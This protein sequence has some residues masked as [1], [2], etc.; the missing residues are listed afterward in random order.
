MDLGKKLR[1]ALARIAKLPVVDENAVKG[2]IK[3]LQR[4]LISSDVNVKLVFELSKR[5]EKRALHSEK[6]EALTLREHVLKVVYEELVGLMG[7]GYEPKIDK[8][9]ILMVG[10]FGS[11]KTTSTAKLAYFYK[12][13]GL[14]VLVVGADVERPAA[15]EQLEQ[16][17]EKVGVRFFSIKGEK[18][19]AKVVK[20]ALKGIKEDV[21]I[22][23]SAGRSAFDSELSK[24]LKGIYAELKPDETYLVLNADIGQVAGRQAE[25]FSSISPLTGVIVTKMDGSGKGGGALSA[26]AASNAKIAFVGIGEKIND[27]EVYDAKRFV[28]RLLGMPDIK[29]LVE[30]IESIQKEEQLEEMEG[31]ELTIENFYKQLNAAKKMGPLGNVLG[32]MGMSDVPKE[33]LNTGEGKLK[34][35][36]AMINSMTKAERKDASLLKKSNSRIERVANGAGCEVKDVKSFLNEF[37]K[38]EKMMNMFKKNRGFRKQMEKMMKGGNLKGL[39]M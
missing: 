21:V 31:E 30:K 37:E 20:E 8:H 29:G 5:I 34:R 6:M 28:G 18:N 36:E 17:A 4:I 39:G 15:Q 13:R 11:G 10:L 1:D 14:S 25:E 3:E 9:R 16:L 32:M 22:V 24:E 26:V 35:Y 23:D 7:T 19:A 12:S 27:L 38:M 2:L 33:V